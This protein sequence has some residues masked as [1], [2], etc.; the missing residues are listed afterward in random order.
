MALHQPERRANRGS[1][2]AGAD[3]SAGGDGEPGG[4][5]GCHGRSARPWWGLTPRRGEV[6]EET[7]PLHWS[8]EGPALGKQGLP[9]GR[10]P[11]GLWVT[12][13]ATS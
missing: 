1:G 3:E 9:S 12:L 2:P 4:C 10:R 6:C 8:R 5:C 7:E 13:L 11:L